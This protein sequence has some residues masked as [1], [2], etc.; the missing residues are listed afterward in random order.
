[1]STLFSQTGN[2]KF[3]V[4]PYGIEK[5]MEYMRLRYPD[6]TIYVTENGKQSNCPFTYF[7]QFMMPGF[8]KPTLFFNL[9]A[10]I[11]W[12]FCQSQYQFCQLHYLYWDIW[13]GLNTPLLLLPTNGRNFSAIGKIF[14]QKNPQLVMIQLLQS[15]LV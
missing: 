13:Y 7:F 8:L 15:F 10:K 11:S 1:M 9:I 5:A 3:F 2:D 4:V 6:I 12:R 14:S